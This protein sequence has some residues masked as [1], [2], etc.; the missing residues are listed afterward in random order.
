LKFKLFINLFICFIYSKLLKDVTADFDPKRL[1]VE[2]NLYCGNYKLVQDET[3]SIPLVK[4]VKPFLNETKVY[5]LEVPNDQIVFDF[6]NFDQEKY[7]LND[8]FT[9]IN[10]KYHT[11]SK[12]KKGIV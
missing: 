7:G 2:V 11:S 8:L 12:L 3:S 4:S 10:I 5:E 6:S 1:I 9:I